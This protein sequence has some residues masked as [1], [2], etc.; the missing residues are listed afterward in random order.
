MRIW[1]KI[2]FLT[3]LLFLIMLNVGLF[4]AARFLFSYNLEQEKKKAETDCYFLCQNL[5]HDLSIL[6]RNGRYRDNVVEFLFEGYQTYYQTQN[7]TLSLEKTEEKKNVFVRSVVSEVGKKAEIFA[8]RILSEPYQGY[9]IYYQKRLMDFEEVWRTLKYMFAGISLTM[10]I[11]LCLILYVFMR[12]M[13]K[14]LGRLNESVAS[15]AAGEYG[16]RTVYKDRTVWDKDE[17]SELS[18]NVNKMSETIQKQFQALEEENAKKQQ[19]MDNMAHELKTPLTSIYGYAEYLRYAKTAEEEKYEGLTYIMEESRRLAKMSE[20]MLSMRLF[21]KEEREPTAVDL[22][23][24]SDHI[25]KILSGK[26]QEKNLTFT[27]EF[28]MQTVY[29]EEFL[30]VNLF[31]NLLENA[32]RASKPGGE[33]VF[34]AFLKEEK[35]VFEVVDYGIGME[36]SELEQITEAFYRI[37]KARSRKDGGVGLGLSVAD[38]IVKKMEGTMTFLS[39]PGKGTKVT[40]ILQ[41]PNRDIKS[42]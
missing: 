17:I 14:P 32:I 31:R 5:E 9:R 21:E 29:G 36:E 22:K 28:K 27:K 34:R 7:V 11:L 40:I 26:L 39:A 24:M 38:L 35:Q 18:Q 12:H 42:H 33:I 20:T 25:E 23:A 37:D 4:L 41:L 19:L 6:E 13:L 16:V 3:L 8:E 30:F 15:I 10:S 2:Y 1:Q